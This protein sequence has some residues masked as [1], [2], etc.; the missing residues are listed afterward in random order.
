MLR[1]GGVV[2]IHT[3][4]RGFWSWLE[5]NGGR[6]LR[7]LP[8]GL[9]NALLTVGDGIITL[10]ARIVSGKPPADQTAKSIRQKLQERLFVPGNIG[11]FSIEELARGLGSSVDTREFQAPVT[12]MLKRNMTMTVIGRKK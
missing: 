4:R 3:S 7:S 8:Q 6:T 12:D 10:S 11:M 1:P 5:I 2:V 9:Q